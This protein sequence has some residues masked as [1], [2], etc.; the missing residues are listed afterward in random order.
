MIRTWKQALFIVQPETLLRWHRE[1]FR[2]WLSGVTSQSLRQIL[3]V[4]SSP[5]LASVCPSR[6]SA[7]EN[8][9]PC[10]GYLGHPFKNMRFGADITVPFACTRG[11]ARIPSGA[12]KLCSCSSDDHLVVSRRSFCCGSR[13]SLSPAAETFLLRPPPRSLASLEATSQELIFAWN[14][15]GP[16]Q[17]QVRAHQRKCSLP[18]ASHHFQSVGETTLYWLLGTSV[19]VISTTR[20]SLP[21]LD[22]LQIQEG[23]G[24]IGSRHAILMLL[25]RSS[26]V[27]EDVI[28]G[29]VFSHLSCG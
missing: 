3:M 4:S 27:M 25:R 15:Y 10:T 22:R 12:G 8:I 11:S 24:T 7:T 29:D 6:L 2:L 13:I 26:Q 1:L 21:F 18:K 28:V 5:P 19:R 16:W 23:E 20:N 9:L 14:K 17:K